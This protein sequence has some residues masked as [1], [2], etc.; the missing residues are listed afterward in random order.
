MTIPNESLTVEQARERILA[1][2]SA[3]PVVDLPLLQALGLTLAEDLYAP[4]DIP[5][6]ANSGMDG[7]AVRAEDISAAGEA[8]PASLRLIGEI[9]AGYVPTETVA[10]G[11]AMRIMTGAPIPQGADT[12]VPFEET[13][14][15][16][17]RNRGAK[18]ADLREIGIRS[19][20]PS[21]ANVRPSGEDVQRGALVLASGT[22]LRPAHLGVAASLGFASVKAVRP[23]TVAILATGDE[24]REP[25]ETLAPGQI[26][27]S[28]SYST[29]AQ[30]MSCGGVPQVIGIARDTLDDLMAKFRMGL[31]ADFFITSAGV[32][33]GEYDLVKDVLSQHGSMSFWRV[34]IRPG[35][36]LAFGLLERP[37]GTK[38]P[39]LG[40]P[41]NPV[42]SM[43]AFDQFAR[44]ALLKMQ[45]KLPSQRPVVRATLEGSLGHL[46][47]RRFYARVIVERMSDGS[48]V[49]RPSGSQGSN[50]L[51]ALAIANGLLV[52]PE[53]RTSLDPDEKLDVELLE[54]YEELLA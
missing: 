50:V 51:T 1:H 48:F 29:A 20:L 3:L 44:P 2:V 10:A 25:G 47:G 41:G 22:V 49:A 36:P 54:G 27:N 9:A 52:V 24:L 31:N 11:T 28:N 53:G 5:P 21:G 15:T 30:V 38:A 6:L 14:E 12:V 34:H 39:H 23:P 8:S 33:T 19:P 45:G 26:Y 16:D 7:Y 46:D 4:F 13:D 42:S 37:D 32:S 43:V 17:Q 40:L 18:S 35:R